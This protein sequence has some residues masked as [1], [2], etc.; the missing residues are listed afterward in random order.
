MILVMVQLGYPVFLNF[1]PT[2]I[3]SLNQRCCLEL[4]VAIFL[5]T[6]LYSF[7]I[8]IIQNKILQ[9]YSYRVI[10]FISV[11]YLLVCHFYL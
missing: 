4:L 6:A 3:L 10:Y 7:F 8:N 9:L 2:E 11:N 1:S 5:L